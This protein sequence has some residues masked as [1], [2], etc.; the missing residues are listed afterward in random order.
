MYFKKR[1]GSLSAAGEGAPEWGGRQ[2]AERSKIIA[3]T[4]S[5]IDFPAN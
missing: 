2:Q 1:I 3:A 5:R 4:R